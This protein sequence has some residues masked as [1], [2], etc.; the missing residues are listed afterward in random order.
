[1]SLELTVCDYIAAHS[2]LTVDTDLFVGGE[3]SDASDSFVT[4]IGSPG[5]DSESGLQIRP[6][7]VISKARGYEDAQDLAYT[8]HDLLGNKPGFA[9]VIED[10]FYSEV[11]NAPFPL[12]QDEKGRHIFISNYIIRKRRTEDES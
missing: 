11:L 3:P 9:D 4:I 10:T 8:V 7:Q 5:Y 1:V 2:S 12:D 6:F